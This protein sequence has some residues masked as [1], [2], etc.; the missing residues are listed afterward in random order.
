MKVLLIL[1][2]YLAV[3]TSYPVVK[4][5][6]LSA[7]SEA[8]ETSKAEPGMMPY[9]EDALNQIMYALFTGTNEKFIFAVIPSP[10][11][12]A[13]WTFEELQTALRDPKTKSDYRPALQEAITMIQQKKENGEDMESI[14][15]AIPALDIS[16]WTP[17]DLNEALKSPNTSSDLRTYVEKARKELQEAL[18][19]GESRDTIYMVTPVGLIAPKKD[20]IV[21]RKAS[22]YPIKKTKQG[23]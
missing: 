23:L 20:F 3:A 10:S 14:E 8:I 6:T 1:S 19:K 21:S 7:L 12:K 18:E 15:V 22:K 2:V 16:S 4:T 11:S 17:L 5:W 9:L 13:T